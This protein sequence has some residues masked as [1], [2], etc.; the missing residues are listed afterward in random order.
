[1]SIAFAEG[2]FDRLTISRAFA[3]G[4]V[5][6]LKK[7][8]YWDTGKVRKCEVYDVNGYLKAKVYCRGDGTIEK[9]DRFN[10]L[11]KRIEEALYDGCGRLKTG[12]DGW[13]AM[14][15]IYSG[16][17]LLY[18]IKY[19]ETG[20]PTEMKMYSESGK[21]IARRYRDDV[22]FNAYEQASMYML[23]GGQSA[24]FYDPKVR[25]EDEAEIS[26]P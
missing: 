12:I 6:S 22:S 14:R 3:E 5:K 21:L 18:E 26:V 19:D 16:P 7:F 23:L 20:K 1:V 9:V 13:A 8:E 24:A 2:W 25:Y 17:M 11:S 15:W 10:M 4:E